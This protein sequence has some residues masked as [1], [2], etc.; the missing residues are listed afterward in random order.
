MSGTRRVTTLFGILLVLGGC[1]MQPA[2]DR[3]VLAGAT[4]IDP[5]SGRI[6]DAHCITIEGERIAT[7]APCEQRP[8]S[9]GT[10][11][12]RGKWIIPGL[13]DMHVHA[14]WHPDVFAP[15]FEQFVEH[16]VVGV[17]DMG[18]DMSLLPVARGYLADTA[19]DGPT[20]VAAGPFI[21]GPE[22]INPGL[23][24][25]AADHGAGVAAARK[26][27]G[28]G[29][30]FLKIYTLLP[31]PAV[32]GVFEEAGRLGLDVIGHLP[33][34]LPLDE[35]I[36]LGMH[37]I[38]HM[39]VEIGGLCDVDD[40]SACRE[41]FGKLRDAGICLAPTLIVRKRR[42]ELDSATLNRVARLDMQPAVVAEDWDRRRAERLPIDS[43][44]RRRLDEQFE[45]ELE[46]TRFAV[47]AGARIIAGTD[48][49]DLFVP[50]GASLHDELELLVY[51]GMSKMAALRAATSVA[52][53]CLGAP[54]RGRI[55]A[56]AVA[57]LL[58]LDA[59]PLASIGNTRR[60]GA[61]IL[62]G[63]VVD[64][65]RATTRP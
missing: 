15:F 5:A 24:M 46:L 37:G 18:G 58:V 22:P 59:D 19:I 51:A 54:D 2:Q 28:A 20:L 49:G 47:A 10:I 33:A 41:V 64:R 4:I 23:S 43:A 29:A 30:D 21:D 11:D 60:I 12:V 56:G 39:A 25:P 48:A 9:A 13:W 45:R 7:L 63:R 38:E 44:E 57:D 3:L 53:D 35:A 50:P 61:V 26:A 31:A 14:L 6:L 36:D 1:P 62:R 8:G 32:R 65:Q 52:A 17:R 55:E 27:A 34:D 16:G 40:P 42:T